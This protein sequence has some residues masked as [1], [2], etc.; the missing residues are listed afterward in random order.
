MSL[1]IN[2]SLTFSFVFGL[3]YSWS[4][5]AGRLPG[6]TDNEVKNYWNSHLRRKLMNMGVDPNNHRLSG[7]FPSLHNHRHHQ[8]QT[9]SGT[10]ITSSGLKHNINNNVIVSKKKD[11][12]L[13]DE[14]AKAD[15]DDHQVGVFGE[16]NN[17]ER[18]VSDAASGLEDESYGGCCLPDLNLDLTISIP[19]SSSLSIPNTDNS[20]THYGEENKQNPIHHH[21]HEYSKSSSRDQIHFASSPTLVLF[22]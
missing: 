21:H 9:M 17:Y 15:H 16:I 3:I 5:I 8:N 12:D 22:Q 20:A 11:N 6:R 14:P 10:S 2:H 13:N 19:N 7:K 4:L 1:L 18:V